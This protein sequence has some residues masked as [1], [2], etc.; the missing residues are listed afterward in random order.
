[1]APYRLLGLSE[2]IMERFAETRA[3]LRGRGQL[4]PDFDLLIAS[5]ALHHDL[6]ILTLNL[7]H[8]QR[9]PDIKLYQPT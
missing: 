3:S 1:M 5:T 9:I 4:I 7:R 8:F 2:P 6:T